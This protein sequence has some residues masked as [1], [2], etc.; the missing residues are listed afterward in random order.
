MLYMGHNL[1]T[2]SYSVYT[3]VYFLELNDAM[4]MISNDW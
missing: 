3:L 1:H 2:H 4:T